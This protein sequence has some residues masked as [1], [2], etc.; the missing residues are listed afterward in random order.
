MI[1]RAGMVF[2]VILMSGNWGCS[3]ARFPSDPSFALQN[4]DLL[5]QD[6]DGGPMCEAI[7]A[8]TEGYGGVD[9]THV[10]VA[11][12]APDGIS[13]LEAIPTDGVVLT[14]L[15]EFLA[16]SS[17]RDGHPKVVVGRL[18]SSYQSRIPAAIE[19]GLSKLGR[20]YDSVFEINNGAY[21]CSELVYEMFARANNDTPIFDLQPMTFKDPKTNETFPVWEEYFAQLGVPI[22]EGHPGTNPGAI[23]R[24][25]AITVVHAYSSPRDW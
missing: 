7:E 22:P 23:S 17:S 5:F 24:S 25:S 9:F 2:V 3:L 15:S 4:G 6:L 10:G 16:R 11:V 1:R 8:V 20:P 19:Y 18:K 12:V 21:Y 14:P 13:V